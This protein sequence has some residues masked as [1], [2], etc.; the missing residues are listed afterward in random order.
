MLINL[1]LHPMN[2]IR[3]D[4]I[5]QIFWFLLAFYGVKFP[6]FALHFQ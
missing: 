6:T 5:I 4:K 2:S 1:H 3:A